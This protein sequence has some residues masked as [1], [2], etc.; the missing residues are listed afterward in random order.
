LKSNGDAD[1]LPLHVDEEDA[2]ADGLSLVADE[3]EGADESVWLNIPAKTIRATKCKS[4]IVP[5]NGSAALHIQ[6]SITKMH[7]TQAQTTEMHAISDA[8][9]LASP[10]ISQHNNNS[11][12]NTKHIIESRL[13]VKPVND[14]CD[15]VK[16]SACLFVCFG[17]VLHYCWL[18]FMV[19]FN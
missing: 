19:N 9:R 15:F 16:N 6:N 11:N 17:S 2:D 7:P 12:Q 5:S 4:V 8:V 1:V 10:R 18:V 3:D 14:D 13:A